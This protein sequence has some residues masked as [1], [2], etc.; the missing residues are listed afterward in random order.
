MKL[1]ESSWMKLNQV[2][3]FKLFLG[4]ICELKNFEV[5]NFHGDIS[6][7]QHRLNGWTSLPFRSTF[8]APEALNCK[9]NFEQ[10]LQQKTSSQVPHTFPSPIAGLITKQCLPLNG[11]ISGNY[12]SNSCWI[13][14]LVWLLLFSRLFL[15][16]ETFTQIGS[17]E[18]DTKSIPPL[19]NFLFNMGLWRLEAML[20]SLS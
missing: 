9:Q 3:W 18:E 15:L 8:L 13:S 10:E 12:T 19:S 16:G 4:Y 7:V 14:V 11:S 17:Y 1:V 5:H 20:L 6:I 2:T